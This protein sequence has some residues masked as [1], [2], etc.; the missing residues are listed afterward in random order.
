MSKKVK[1]VGKQIS[2][3]LLHAAI[4]AAVTA[5]CWLKYDPKNGHW[6][7]PWPAWTTA[8][9]GLA[10]LGHFCIV[11]TSHEDHGYDTYRRQQGKA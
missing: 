9:W 5:L 1:P 11:F 7:Y 10:L 3:L 6:A 8:A 2:M 4:F